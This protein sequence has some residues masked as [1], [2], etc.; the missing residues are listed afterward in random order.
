MKHQIEIQ[1]LVKWMTTKK[2]LYASSSKESKKLYCT[3]IGLYEIYYK[4]ELV[5]ST[6]SV[7]DAVEKYNEL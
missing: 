1:E 3:L 7:H 2:V 6:L 5:F 4:G